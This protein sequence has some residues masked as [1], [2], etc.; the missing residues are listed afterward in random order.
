MYRDKTTAAVPIDHS[1]EPTESG[2]LDS[3]RIH[4]DAASAAENFTTSIVSASGGEY[5]VVLD[6]EAMSALT[7]YVYQPTRPIPFF[8]GDKIR[9]VYPN[10]TG[11]DYGLE[12]IWS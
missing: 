5:S 3:V 11:N 10:A 12:I 4:L 2:C 8:K 1:V 6:V 7:D 9:V